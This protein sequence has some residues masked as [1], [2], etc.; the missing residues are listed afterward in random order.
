MNVV[1][2]IKVRLI[3]KLGKKKCFWFRNG[4]DLTETYMDELKKVLT[5]IRK[6]LK[7]FFCFIVCSEN[8]IFCHSHPIRIA[9]F[10]NFL[11]F[12]IMSKIKT[13]ILFFIYKKKKNSGQFFFLSWSNNTKIMSTFFLQQLPNV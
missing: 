12:I 7:K 6:L 4:D 2:W 3:Y 1:L 5:K 13:Y 9:L 10:P 8:K 11:N